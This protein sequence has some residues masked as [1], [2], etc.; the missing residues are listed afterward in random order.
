MATTAVF[1]EILIIGLEVEAWL[2]LLL[3]TVFGTGWI[4]L[5]AVQD[6]ASLVTVGVLAL[7]YVLGVVT[8]RLTDTLL[9]RCEK[10][11]RGKRLKARFSKYGDGLKGHQIS[12]M[13]MTVMHRSDG[14]SRFLDYQRSRWRIARAT[15]FNLALS[16]VFAA[17]YLVV[18]TEHAVWAVVPV[19]GVLLLVPVTYFAAVRIQDAWIRALADAYKVVVGQPPA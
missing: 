4:E 6:F 11:K 10:T 16:G 7:A 3:L 8:D 9:D 18:R 19:V 2:S 12:W 1:A 13:R 5:G 14:M 15:V 17:L